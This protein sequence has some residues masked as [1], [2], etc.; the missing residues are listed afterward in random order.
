MSAG[1]PIPSVLPASW[2]LVRTTL[3]GAAW[4]TNHGLSVIGSVATEQDGKRWVHLSCARS[5]RLPSWF[6]LREV[7][8]VLLGDAVAYQVLPSKSRYINLH[9]N[10]LHLFHCLDGD[11]L[12][13]FTRGGPTL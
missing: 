2:S 8:D 10:C 5:G 13:D 3:D 7:R 11:P 12:P 4:V 6:D 1:W 9:P